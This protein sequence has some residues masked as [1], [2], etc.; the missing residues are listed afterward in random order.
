MSYP[1]FADFREKSRSFDGLVT[2][3]VL[4]A[5]FAQDPQAQSQLKTG[6]LVSGNF[7]SVLEIQAQLGR[8][9]RREE[10]EVPGRDAVVVLSHDLWKQEFAADPS[11]INRHVRLSD[12][13]F[14]KK[15]SA[16]S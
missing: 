6:L 2:Y 16:K 8:T 4:G 5:G 15:N 3:D 1:D 14:T 9:F 10:D 7:F 11:V 13:D 12:L